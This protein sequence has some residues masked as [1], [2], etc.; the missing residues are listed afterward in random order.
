[1]DRRSTETLKLLRQS[2]ITRS[3]M[4]K[5]IKEGSRDQEPGVETLWDMKMITVLQE[6]EQNGILWI[7]E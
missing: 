1:M 7:N 3:D 6:S 4:E 2:I 5:L